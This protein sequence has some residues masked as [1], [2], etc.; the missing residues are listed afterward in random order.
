MNHPFIKHL[1]E[2]AS[3]I[4]GRVAIPDAVYDDRVMHAAAE[5]HKRGWLDV[6][7]VGSRRACQEMAEKVGVDISG[8][9]ILDADELPEFADYCAEYGRIRAKENLTEQ[10]IDALMRDPA[11]LSCMLHRKGVVDAVCSGIHYSTSDLARPAIKILGMKPGYQMM[12]AAAVA[13]F[14]HTPIGDNLVYVTADGTILPTPDSEQLAEIAIL[15]ADAAK[16]FLEDVPRVAMLSFSTLGSAKHEAVDKVVRALELAKQKRPDL[17]IDGEFQID[18]AILPHVA[19]K[20]VKRPS[21]VAGR[22]NVLIWPS[23]EAGNI[24]IKSLMMMGGGTFVG[25]TFLGIN[26][27]VGDHSRG[28]TIEE[29]IPYIAYVGAQITKRE[30]A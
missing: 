2:Q 12:T 16:T 24:A 5:V 14:E 8:V 17:L 22:A 26:G 3:S 29:I 30:A 15:A 27:L 6:V 28:A 4:H 18:A 7:L 19:A 20:K 1:I 13:A 9:E 25:A 10:Q 23:L 11:Y 21:E